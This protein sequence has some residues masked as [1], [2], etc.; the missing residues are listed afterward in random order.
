MNTKH[1]RTLVEALNRLP[2]PIKNDYVDMKS[3]KEPVCGTPGCFAGLISIVADD[4]PELKQLYGGGK[5]Y[6]SLWEFALNEYLECNFPAWAGRHP[7]IWDNEY[8]TFMFFSNDAFSAINGNYLN[9]KNIIVH[10][11]SAYNRW[12]ELEKKT[13]KE[14]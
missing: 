13:N 1:F 2:E 6:Y 11:T 8:G 12:V 3:T 5:Y 14:H 10:L 4:I 9:H 7:E